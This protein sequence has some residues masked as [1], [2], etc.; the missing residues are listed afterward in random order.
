MDEQ[1]GVRK[2]CA[3]G[4]TT[5]RDGLPATLARRRIHREPGSHMTYHDA[6]DA[7]ITREEARLEIAK[8]DAPGGFQLFLQ[9]AGDKDEY[10][11]HEVLDW[12]GY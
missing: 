9:E 5:P 10:L 1:R 8:H 6:L 7:E 4:R 2:R 3:Q 11:G 12:L